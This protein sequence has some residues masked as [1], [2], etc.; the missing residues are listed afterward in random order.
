M[1]AFYTIFQKMYDHQKKGNKEK[2]EEE[3]N[4][5]FFLLPSAE[6]IILNGI[7]Y[8][9]FQKGPYSTRAKFQQLQMALSNIFCNDPQKDRIVKMFSRTQA[10]YR[11]FSKFAFLYRWKKATIQID[12]DLCMNELSPNHPRVFTLYQ[13]RLK[14]LFSA[15]DMINIIQGN[16]SHTSSFHPQPLLTKNPYTNVL[17]THTHL[18]NIYFF[19][20][21]SDYMMPELFHGYFTCNFDTF[22]FHIKYESIIVDHSIKN[23]IYTSHHD[24]LYPI[25]KDMLRS[26]KPILKDICIHKD[27]PKQTLV[28]IFKPYLH[29]FFIHSHG[30]YGSY[31]HCNADFVLKR[32]LKRFVAYNPSFGRRYRHLHNDENMK[33]YVKY[34]FD[35]KHIHFYCER[36][37]EHHTIVYVEENVEEEDNDSE[38]DSDDEEEYFYNNNED[39]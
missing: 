25:L 8:H 26:Y 36:Q 3:D 12:A 28:T 15:K 17:L 2:E 7:M 4:K 35:E 39:D 31:Q 19:I 29:L 20:R 5:P 1:A 23:F 24:I 37:E 9:L 27:F 14:Y 34:T 13:N 16:L 33:K 22:E 38:F 30:S 32:K 10:A 18:Y 21:N 11:G 6:M